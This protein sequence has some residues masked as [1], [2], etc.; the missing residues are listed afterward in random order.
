M[1]GQAGGRPQGLQPQQQQQQF[2]AWLE[3]QAGLDACA[4]RATQPPPAEQQQ[5]QQQQQADEAV[6]G[7]GELV[8]SAEADKHMKDIKQRMVEPV[9]AAARPLYGKM[10]DRGNQKAI[11]A[12]AT[13]ALAEEVASGKVD[14]NNAA[15][16]QEHARRAVGR[17]MRCRGC[18]E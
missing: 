5:Q 12:I 1:H 10:G 15:E 16:V 17:A 18:A 9:K 7:T 2:A 14:P 8:A 6:Q 3:E 11:I 4:R 13:R